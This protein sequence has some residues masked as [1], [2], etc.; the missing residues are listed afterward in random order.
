MII[1]IRVKTS[2]KSRNPLVVIERNQN[3][4]IEMTSHTEITNY[5]HTVVEINNLCASSTIDFHLWKGGDKAAGIRLKDRI[6][7]LRDYYRG[8]AL[9]VEN[10][11]NE[12]NLPALPVEMK[13]ELYEDPK[14]RGPRIFKAEDGVEAGTVNIEYPKEKGAGAYLAQVAEII[15]GHDPVYVILAG[16]KNL[17]MEITN[18]KVDTRYLIRVAGVFPT[19]IGAYCN[20][21]PF[22]TKA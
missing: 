18:L 13:F 9:C 2:I 5:P 21:I 16:N 6:F 12:N 20:P 1:I 22:R 8:T 7:L 14:P 15:S 4:A 10:Y 11:A 3:M 19:G 17:A